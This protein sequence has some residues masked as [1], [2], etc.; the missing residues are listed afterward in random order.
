MRIV[1]RCC[2]PGGFKNRA[3]GGER[4]DS[5]RS[6][7]ERVSKSKN[8]NLELSKLMFQMLPF[9]ESV[10]ELRDEAQ[11]AGNKEVARVTEAMVIGFSIMKAL[12]ESGMSVTEMHEKCITPEWPEVVE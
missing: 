10:Y 7:E 5:A 11:R 6:G 3:A 8:L 4:R 12:E 9:A 1:R 2:H